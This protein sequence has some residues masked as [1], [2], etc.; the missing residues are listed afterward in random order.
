MSTFLLLSPAKINLFLK[1][2]NRRDDG[3]HNII[4]AVQKVNLFDIIK[5]KIYPNKHFTIVDFSNKDIPE[6]NTVTEIIKLFKQETSIDFGIEVKIIKK[7]PTQAGLG[8]GSS[9]A[10]IV[11]NF[12]NNFFKK[13]LH[14]DKLVKI[15]K[16]VG[17]DVPIFVEEKSFLV[18]SGIG[19]KIL[20]DFKIKNPFK[21]YVLIKPEIN[22]S[23]K[24][25]Y[26][27]LNKVLTKSDKNIMKKMVDV[28]FGYNDL[29]NSAF[30]IF[31]EIKEIKEKLKKYSEIS[32][33]TGSGSVICGLYKTKKELI[34]NLPK[35][36]KEFKKYK[37]FVCRNL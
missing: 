18:I 3:Y 15:G 33:M 29:E 10:G 5:L 17:A 19:D 25:V 9:N 26:S 1:V 8:G 23:T 27:Y 36:E 37:I 12:L 7:I 4:S 6:K 16:K 20:N 32:L 13:I 21:W 35:I 31:P 28:K 24:K 30:R 22:L 14:K 2:L 11:L 34:E